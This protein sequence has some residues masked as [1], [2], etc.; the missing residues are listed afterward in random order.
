MGQYFSDKCLTLTESIDCLLCILLEAGVRSPD[1]FRLWFPGW[2]Y[3]AFPS[4]KC[5]KQTH[6]VPFWKPGTSWTRTFHI[7]HEN[8][9]VPS[10]REVADSGSF[11]IF[12][13][14]HPDGPLEKVRCFPMPRSWSAGVS[15]SP[16]WGR[17][18][19]SLIG[20]IQMT[21]DQRRSVF[22]CFCAHLWDNKFPTS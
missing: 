5:S 22:I 19:V 17:Q 10:M 3:C 6:S 21:R 16:V 9:V 20:W 14:A 13:E 11:L 1:C 8:S 7:K 15:H 4:A 18:V 2:R 12:L